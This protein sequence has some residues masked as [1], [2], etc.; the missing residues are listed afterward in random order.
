MATISKNHTRAMAQQIAGE[1]LADQWEIGPLLSD[2]YVPIRNKHT[3]RFG[4]ALAGS[5]SSIDQRHA[6]ALW[7]SPRPV[8]S[9]PD[10][11]FGHMVR[12]AAEDGDENQVAA[13]Y[14]RG[15]D[16]YFSGQ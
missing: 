5:I 4:R 6:L 2:G 14:S 9:D 3:C 16:A 12:T 7:L 8:D 13:A 1:W 11:L 15:M 10:G